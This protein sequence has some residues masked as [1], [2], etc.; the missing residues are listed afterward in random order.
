ML[1]TAII[2][3]LILTILIGLWASRRVENS[4]DFIMAGRNL[5][6]A[7]NAAALFALWFGSET[8]FGASSE[9]LEHGLIGVIEDPFGGALCFLILALFYVR[10]LYRMN[11]LTISDLFRDHYG[12][13][14]ELV[15]AVAMVVSFF[16]YVAAQLVALGLIFST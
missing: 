4:T 11:I 2:F 15:S 9:F 13:T 3:Y 1:I 7:F 6:A 10:K 14:V 16:G 8:V 5:P 12:K